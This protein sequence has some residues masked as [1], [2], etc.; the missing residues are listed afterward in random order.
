MSARLGTGAVLAGTFATAVAVPAV[1]GPIGAAFG[2]M[3]KVLKRG[4]RYVSS[5]AIGGPVVALDMR[6]F[7]LKDLTL[8]GC[9]AWDAPVFPNLITAIEVATADLCSMPSASTKAGTMTSPP[10]TPQSAPS[11]PATRPMRMAEMMNFIG[12]CGLQ[13]FKLIQVDEILSSP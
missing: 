13:F 12:G 11:R 8:I 6:N 7:Y 2:A 3:L 9:T 5:G 10:P 4:G 1:P